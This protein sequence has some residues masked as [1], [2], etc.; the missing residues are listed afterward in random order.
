MNKF[1]MTSVYILAFTLSN[2]A[3][4][5]DSAIQQNDMSDDAFQALQVT[6]CMVYTDLEKN[7]Q[8]SLTSATDQP[9]ESFGI[10]DI[11]SYAEKQ[12]RVLGQLGLEG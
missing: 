10:D 1:F 6:R 2:L 8:S 3:Y 12:N 9:I 4:G 5:L 11:N 7:M